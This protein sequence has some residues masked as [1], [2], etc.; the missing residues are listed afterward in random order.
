MIVPRPA[1]WA[2]AVALFIFAA[3]VS[4]AMTFIMPILLGL[5]R[6]APR[7]ACLGILAAWL[8]PIAAAAAIHAVVDRI[9]VG[10]EPAPPPRRCPF[11][12]ATSWWVGFVAWAT[13]IFVTMTTA[14][15]MLVIN[16]PPF[17]PPEAIWNLAAALTNSVSGLARSALW[18]IL[19]A[20]VYELEGSARDAAA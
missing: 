13:I 17:V 9:L 12:G 4:L 14:F 5:M 15:V 11:G 6:H 18:V 19:A 7:L 10:G 2:S 16:P 8:S 1:A 20:Y 3:G